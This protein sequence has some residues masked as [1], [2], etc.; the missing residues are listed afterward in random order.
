M[1]PWPNPIALGILP[2]DGTTAIV[3]PSTGVFQ[4]QI[5]SYVPCDS[6]LGPCVVALPM[7]VVDLAVVIVADVGGNAPSAPIIYEAQ[8]STGL[9]TITTFDRSW[10]GPPQPLYGASG[11]LVEAFDAVWLVF[12][13]AK[14]AWVP[15]N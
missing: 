5:N 4:A 2:P 13:K 3:L 12:L 14:N 6:T 1:N 7:N 11:R 9:G 8:G 10:G 15:G